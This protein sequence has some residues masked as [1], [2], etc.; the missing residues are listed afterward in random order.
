TTLVLMVFHTNRQ[1]ADPLLYR[2]L[3]LNFSLIFPFTQSTFFQE[4]NWVTWSLGVEICFSII[5]PVIVLSINRIGWI[6]TVTCV[7]ILCFLVRIIGRIVYE[8][9]T[10]P[11]ISFPSDTIF[12]RLDDFVLG[13]LVAHLYV[14]NRFNKFL[15]LQFFVGI[16]LIFLSFIGWGWWYRGNGDYILSS[17]LSMPFNLG[18]VLAINSLLKKKTIFTRMISLWPLQLLGM[19]C[20]SLYLWH[21]VIVQEYATSVHSITSYPIYLLLTFVI[22]WFTYRYIEFRGV[23]NWR[24]LLP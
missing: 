15:S 3:F 10:R 6:K 22:S 2:S 13:M 16:I 14:K 5:F 12:G 18:L 17:G 21:G 20:Y 23:E 11:A 4:P 24:K 7:L 19:M 9:P 1:L 8:G